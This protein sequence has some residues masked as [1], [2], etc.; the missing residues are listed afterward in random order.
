[1]RWL[2]ACCG[3]WRLNS[4]SCDDAIIYVAVH[5]SRGDQHPISYT[6]SS[7]VNGVSL[8]PK[9]PFE[10]NREFVG[11]YS[12]RFTHSETLQALSSAKKYWRHFRLVGMLTLMFNGVPYWRLGLHIESYWRCAQC[13]RIE[14]ISDEL[15]ST[16]KHITDE[17]CWIYRF[18]V[19]LPWKRYRKYALEGSKLISD[20]HARCL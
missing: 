8:G 5:S 11:I 13:Q 17:Q 14:R 19:R 12:P 7:V 2:T 4:R 1:M 3:V 16:H 20:P 10:S 9:M 15:A 6:A 18:N